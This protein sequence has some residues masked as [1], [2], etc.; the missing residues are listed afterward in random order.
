[1]VSRQDVLRVARSWIGTP[2]HHQGR[3]KGVGVDCCGLIIGVMKE[4]GLNDYDIDGYSRTAD[5]VNIISEFNEQCVP[6]APTSV[7]SGD[8][9]IFRIKNVPQHCGILSDLDGQNYVIH[10]YQSEADHL[11]FVTEHILDDWWISRIV[12]C[13]AFPG[14]E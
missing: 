14:V 7:V 11:N 13:Y 10:A 9:L 4:L 12:A 3:V 2:Y 5:G 6:I 8:I 1:M